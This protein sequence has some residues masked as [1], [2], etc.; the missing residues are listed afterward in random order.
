[1]GGEGSMLH[2]IKSLQS[3][4]ILL[5]ERNFKKIRDS[6]IDNSQKTELKFK[7]LSPTELFRINRKFVDKVNETYKS[8]LVFI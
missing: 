3:N 1:M 7:E 6:Y 2:A 8:K 5:K 4:R